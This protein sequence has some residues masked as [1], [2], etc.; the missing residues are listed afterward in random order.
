MQLKEGWLYWGSPFDPD[1]VVAFTS[2]QEGQTSDEASI[3]PPTHLCYFTWI[4]GQW[5]Q[6]QYLG[7][8]KELDMHTRNGGKEHY[9]QALS[10]K[11]RFEADQHSWRYDP[12]NPKAGADRT[13]RL[14]QVLDSG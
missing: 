12:K 4:G 2:L 9:L 6:R 7:H 13:R 1:E 10:I 5:K 3:Y 14:G 11:G 8:G